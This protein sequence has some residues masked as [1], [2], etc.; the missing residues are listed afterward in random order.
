M[1]KQN[2]E[3]HIG[4]QGWNYDGWIGSF[5]PRSARPADFLE[6][7]CRAFG[8]VEIDSSFY[9]IPS[10]AAIASW[11]KRS[12]ENFTF[13]L[14]LT[15][16][17][18]HQNRLQDSE[19][20]LLRF[21]ERVRGLSEK[22]AL[23]LIQLPPDFSPRSLPALE[24][25]LPLLPGDLRFAIEFRD[26]HWLEDDIGEY[27]IGLLNAN[28]VALT[29]TDGKWFARETMIHLTQRPTT[30]FAYVRWLGSRE[31]TNYSRIQIHREAEL[32]Q[33][34][35]GFQALQQNVST[36][37]GYFNNHFAGHSPASANQFKSLLQLAVVK[38]EE[39]EDQPSL[40]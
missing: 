40:F 34:T 23:I 15:Q 28:K 2:C 19:E 37:Y 25:F 18:T 5:Y 32:E 30:D 27:V 20:I 22:L 9:A 33:W 26:H 4:T 16:E 29:L 38:P 21:C 6:L 17:I 14:K 3:I 1:D 31:I 39:L 7:Y 24:K 8:T 10:V 11:Y 35:Q 13:S 36:I 12:P